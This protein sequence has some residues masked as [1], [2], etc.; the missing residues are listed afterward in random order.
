MTASLNAVRPARTAQPLPK[1]HPIRPLPPR[2]SHRG[3]V[4]SFSHLLP[5]SRVRPTLS[6]IPVAR[7]YANRRRCGTAGYPPVRSTASRGFPGSVPALSRYVLAPTDAR[8]RGRSGSTKTAEER[9]LSFDQLHIPPPRRTHIPAVHCESHSPPGAFS[10]KTSIRPGN[11]RCYEA[12]QAI[13]EF[14]IGY[15]S[16]VIQ[17]AFQGFSLGALRH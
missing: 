7:Q 5:F 15:L 2:P 13:M 3:R 10:L 8:A 16:S 9:V 14:T 11:D 4:S 6:T 1:N 17:S 12:A